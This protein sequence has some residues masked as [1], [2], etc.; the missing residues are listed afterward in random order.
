MA[1]ANFLPAMLKKKNSYLET[2]TSGL[3]SAGV[4]EMDLEHGD[5]REEQNLSGGACQDCCGLTHGQGDKR[6]RAYF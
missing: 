6:Q 3:C 4:R 5:H 2:G 1:Q